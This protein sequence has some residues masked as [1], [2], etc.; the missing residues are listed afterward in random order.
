MR[1]ARGVTLLEILVG[2]LVVAIAVGGTMM[3]YV[4]ALRIAREGIFTSEATAFIIQTFERFRSRMACDDAWLD[5]NTCGQGLGLPT[6]W[7]ADALPGGATGSALPQGARVYQVTQGPDDFD[8]D[9]VRDY[10][11]VMVKV[12]WVPP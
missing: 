8:G 5:P 3:S 2:S 1:S 4:T 6:V 12:S 9:G 11:R 10:Y 7:T